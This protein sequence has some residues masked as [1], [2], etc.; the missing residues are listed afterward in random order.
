MAARHRVNSSRAVVSFEL[1]LTPRAVSFLASV[2]APTSNTTLH[3]PSMVSNRF[4]LLV[5]VKRHPWE[6]S[7]FFCCL[8]SLLGDIRLGALLKTV[9]SWGGTPVMSLAEGVE[10]SWGRESQV[11]GGIIHTT[12]SYT[13]GIWL[14]LNHFKTSAHTHPDR[15]SHTTIMFSNTQTHILHLPTRWDYWKCTMLII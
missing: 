7:P 6:L 15:F 14:G 5:H 12:H 13:N 8:S 3:S 11:C 2:S 9:S 1:S 10:I 4:L